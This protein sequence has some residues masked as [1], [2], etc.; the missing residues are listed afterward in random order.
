MQR[1]HTKK[2]LNGGSFDKNIFITKKVLSINVSLTEQVHL[3]L[4]GGY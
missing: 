2:Q 4:N 3:L 1:R